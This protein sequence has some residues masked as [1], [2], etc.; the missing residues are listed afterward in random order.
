[1]RVEEAIKDGETSIPVR[2]VDLPPELEKIILLTFDPIG[3]LA[4]ADADALA[5]L[6]HDANKALN[7]KKTQSTKTLKQLTKDVLGAK[8]GIPRSPSVRDKVESP[9]EESDDIHTEEGY[10]PPDDLAVVEETLVNN[11]AKFSSTNHW[12]LPDIL[13]EH[14]ATPDDAPRQT[15][16]KKQPLEDRPTYFCHGTRPYS[17]SS[18]FIRRYGVLGFYTDDW[19][20]E[21]AYRR[22][23]EFAELLRQEEWRAIIAPDFSVYYE[24]PFP[25]QLFNIYRSRWCARLWQEL[26]FK[27][28]PTLEDIGVKTEDVIYSTLPKEC[29][30]VAFQ[31]RS[32]PDHDAIINQVKSAVSYL[33]TRCVV[34][35]GGASKEKY[36]RPYLPAGTKKSPIEYI[37]LEDHIR[38]TKKKKA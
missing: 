26:G 11:N 31:T 29:P 28:I 15:Y 17:C 27:I 35:Y 7:A 3:M 24:C 25:E 14:L 36:I 1:M 34:M 22:G 16:S 32:T 38:A 4:K 2:V 5:A 6:R 13:P 21:D 37:F 10:N 18:K 33:R 8:F 20:F 9:S 23:T 30:V 19:R 12:E